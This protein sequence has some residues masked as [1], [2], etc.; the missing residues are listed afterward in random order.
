MT[1]KS[2][3]RSERTNI[4][5]WNQPGHG[6]PQAL[7]VDDDPTSISAMLQVLSRV[8][9]DVTVAF[10]GADAV[11]ILK[12]SRFDLMI[13]DWAMPEFGGEHVITTLYNQLSHMEN[14]PD[15]Q[16]L[17]QMPVIIHT[18]MLAGDV[19]L[20]FEIKHFNHVDFLQKPSHMSEL[21]RTISRALAR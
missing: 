1:R 11:E 20:P 4:A 5:I 21:V 10:H 6:S 17:L 2:C 12:D 8:G 14:R 9:C 18:G 15:L 13:L 19:N 16:K 7:V 3:A